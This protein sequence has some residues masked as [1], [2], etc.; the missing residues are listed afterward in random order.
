MRKIQGAIY[1]ALGMAFVA[2]NSAHAAIGFEKSNTVNNDL[3]GSTQ[4]ADNVLETWIGYLTGFLYLIAIA[5]I[6][7]GAFNI[8]TAAGDE[9]KVKKGKT[10]IL[11]A[12][13]GLVVVFIANSIIVWVLTGLFAS[14][15][16]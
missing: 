10:V 14:T 4:T 15:P 11:Q 5:M 16:T 3:Q 6:L 12:V 8:L 9:E 13:A 7:W 2:I 1:S